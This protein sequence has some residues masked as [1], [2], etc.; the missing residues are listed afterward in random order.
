MLFFIS[1]SNTRIGA[2]QLL[3]E[4][5]FGEYLQVAKS[6]LQ[7]RRS[8]VCAHLLQKLLHTLHKHAFEIKAIAQFDLET[9]SALSTLL[10]TEQSSHLEKRCKSQNLR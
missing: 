5:V 7:L 4:Q 3:G 2:L 9:N 6:V 1:A 8:L 10:A